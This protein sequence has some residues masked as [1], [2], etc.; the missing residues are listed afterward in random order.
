M[1]SWLAVHDERRS[2]D[3]YASTQSIYLRHYQEEGNKVTIEQVAV[4]FDFEPEFTADGK[5][6]D[7]LSSALLEDRPEERVRQRYIR[8]L[9]LD[10]NYPL[11]QIRR[12]VA[13][14]AGSSPLM[15]KDG[16]LTRADIV[17]YSSKQAAVSDDQANIILVVECKRPTLTS[18]RNQLASY[19]FNTSAEGAV[20]TNGDDV[21]AFRRIFH[22]HNGLSEAVGLPAHREDWGSVGRTP[23]DELKRPRDVRGLLKLCNNKLHGRGL[24]SDEEDLTMEMVRILLSKAQDETQPGPLPDFYIT[25][26]ENDTEVGRAAVAERVQ[27]LFRRFADDN[28]GVFSEHEKI[29][30]SDRAIADVVGVLQRWQ[31]MTRLDEADEWDVMGE[32]YEQYTHS[33]LKRARGQFFTNR[34]VV[35][36]M[37]GMADPPSGMKVLDPAGGSGGFLTAT[38]RHMR[39]KVIANTKEHSTQREH[40]L[41]NMRRQLFAVEISKRLVKIAKTAM[42]LNGDGHSGMTQGDSLGPFENL[43]SWVRSQCDRGQAGLILTNPPFAGTGDGQISDKNILAD[44]STARRWSANSDGDFLP[45]AEHFQESCPPEMLFFERCVEWLKPGALL[46]IVLPKSFLDTA[47]FRPS[48]ELLFETAQLLAVVN[49]HKNTF[50]PD[51]GVRTCVVLVRKR[52]V[53][54]VVDLDNERIFMALSQRV[55]RDSEGVPIY[56]IATGGEETD[57]VEEDLSEVLADYKLFR[58]D[59]LVESE[60]RFSVAAVRARMAMNINPQFHL[61][62]LNNTLRT[63]QMMDETE[64]WTVTSISQIEPGIKVFKGPRLRTENI[65]VASTNEG[66]AVVPYYTPSAI[67]QDRRDSVKWLDLAKATKRQLAAFEYVKVFRGDI[68]VTRSGSIGRLGYVTNALDGS[69]VSDDAIRVR[70][71]NARLR[72]YVFSFLQSKAAQDQMRIN[73]YGAI[74]QHLEPK[75]VGGLLIPIPDDWNSVRVLVSNAEQFFAAKEQVDRAQGRILSDTDV[76]F[77]VV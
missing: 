48:R 69:I 29:G 24:D 26:E 7:S 40:Q 45:S 12:E 22:P 39:R 37:V 68:L 57:V 34:L 36:M 10:Y 21:Q 77:G 35:Q 53:D 63:V 17:V 3:L 54:E 27:T 44:Y 23:K 72:A 28:T 5:I 4:G 41:A 25:P 15:E 59:T 51:T 31:I 30:V 58:R 8:V 67:L 13:I 50:Q 65:L 56:R 76:A 75:H 74:Q 38:L 16:T 9:N 19:V 43:D 60:F 64:G 73:E 61:P 55:G 46:G 62:N 42:L 14:F 6:V 33:H 18:G 47:T 1:Q 2:V 11:D 66:T 52:L 32:A 70:I 71:R 49:L 20:W